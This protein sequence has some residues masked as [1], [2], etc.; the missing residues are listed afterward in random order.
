MPEKPNLKQIIK[1]DYL[2]LV[3]LIIAAVIWPSFGY[4]M[5]DEGDFDIIFIYVAISIT[6]ISLLIVFFRI[7]SIQS[8]F[9]NCEKI[10]GVI[11]GLWTSKDRGRVTYKYIYKEKEYE[12]GHGIHLNE[13][14]SKLN[15]GDEVT[16]CLKRGNPKK[17]LLREIYF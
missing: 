3:F 12:T 13:K 16:V 7:R 5:I 2:S 6:L 8:L 14:T 15:V 9:L 11:T 10:E 4:V 1:T 17:A